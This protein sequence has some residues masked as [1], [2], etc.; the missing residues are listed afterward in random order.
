MVV[1]HVDTEVTDYAVNINAKNGER[2][3]GGQL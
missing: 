2:G 3:M 1:L